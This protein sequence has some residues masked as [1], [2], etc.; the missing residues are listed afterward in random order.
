MPRLGIAVSGGP[1]P[2]EIVRLVKV[3]DELGYE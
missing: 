1:D 3:A 2:A